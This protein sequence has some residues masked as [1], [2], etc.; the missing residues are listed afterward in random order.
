MKNP[1]YLPSKGF[2]LTQAAQMLSVAKL[3]TDTKFNIPNDWDTEYW[4]YLCDLGYVDR[5][6][7][8]GEFIEM[9]VERVAEV[10]EMGFDIYTL[11][12]VENEDQ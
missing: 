3:P 5:L 12:P 8:C 11:K 7:K 2:Q 1:D 4:E 9:E 10:T 6:D